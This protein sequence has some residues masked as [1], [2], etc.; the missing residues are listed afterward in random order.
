MVTSG[1]GGRAAGDG[2]LVYVGTYTEGSQGRAE[3]IYVCRLDPASGTLRIQQTVPGV[4][5]P[6]YLALA[7]DGRR[8]YAVSEVDDGAVAAFARDPATGRLTPLNR[9]SSHG[10][11]PCH[12]SVHRDY[13]LAANYTTGSVAALPVRPD[14][15]LAPA[16]TVV[17]HEGS[18]VHPRQE[19][20]HA[21]MVVPDPDGRLILAVDL[22]LDRI[23][24]YRLDAESGELTPN[25]PATAYTSPRPGAGPRQIAFH[26]DG[27]RAWVLGELDSTLTTCAYDASRGVL[28]P[29][30]T[31]STLPDGF[32]GESTAADMAVAP[33]GRFVYASNRGHDS[34]AI[35]ATGGPTGRLTAVGH[36]PTHGKTPR[37]FALDPAGVWLLAANQDSDTIV[38]FRVDAATGRLSPSGQAARIPTPVCVVFAGDRPANP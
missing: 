25:E 35:F 9:E 10:A 2:V 18:G 23:M 24:G 4:A 37:A 34:I 27:R 17:R 8:L 26:P 19:G 30:E 28:R 33:S 16:T 15:S 31:L 21:H 32:A 13:V 14:G 22:G 12:L 1:G 11:S 6:S 29:V 5:D 38:S 20:P 7:P 3:G 36:E